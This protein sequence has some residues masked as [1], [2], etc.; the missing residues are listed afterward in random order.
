[1]PQGIHNISVK[2]TNGCTE[3]TATISIIGYPTFF[4][5]NG[6][7][8][9]DTWNLIGLQN[10]PNAKIYIFD[11]YG[12]LIK[13]MSASGIGWD[14]TYNGQPLPTTDYWFTVDYFE[15]GASKFFKSHFSMKR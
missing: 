3:L 6:D 12:K 5:P 1:M 7:G 11:R 10:Q 15:E 9:H 8:I 14:G 2:E 13:Q 4:T